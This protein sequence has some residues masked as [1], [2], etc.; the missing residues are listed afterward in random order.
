MQGILNILLWVVVDIALVWL[1]VKETK[2]YKSIQKVFTCKKCRNRIPEII[3]G[4]TKC[5]KCGT[6]VEIKNREWYHYFLFRNNRIAKN[7][8]KQ[9]YSYRSYIKYS[10]IELAICYV[11]ITA[12]TIC[13]LAEFINIG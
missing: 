6:K 13:L 1:V 2:N 7:N 3:S 4:K 5:S 8:K 10:I 11:G 9:V 12:V